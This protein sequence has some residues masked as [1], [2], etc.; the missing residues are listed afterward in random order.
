MKSLTLPMW[1]LKVLPITLNWFS[2]F[3]KI[4]FYKEKYTNTYLAKE[5]NHDQ[6][7]YTSTYVGDEVNVNKIRFLF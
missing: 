1:I 7:K 3:R 5:F 4:T 6:E 2:F